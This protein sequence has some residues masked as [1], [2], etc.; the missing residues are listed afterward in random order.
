MDTFRLGVTYRNAG[1]KVCVEK[2]YQEIGRTTRDPLTGDETF[3][4]P[5]EEAFVKDGGKIVGSRV[6]WPPDVFEIYGKSG[7]RAVPVMELL[8]NTDPKAVVGEPAKT[9][10]HEGAPAWFPPVAMPPPPPPPPPTPVVE[11][12]P[13]TLKDDV[14]AALGSRNIRTKDFATELGMSH[15]KLLEIVA[16]DE[17]YLPIKAGW[18]RRSTQPEHANT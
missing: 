14:C 16:G 12:I 7:P 5:S 9:A 8:V 15:E 10:T 1:H 18:L 11:A 13:Q 17:R 4:W 2:G 6:T 3:F